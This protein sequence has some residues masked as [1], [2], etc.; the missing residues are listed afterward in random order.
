MSNP[1]GTNQVLQGAQPA[2]SQRTQAAI[3]DA[4]QRTGVDFGYLLAQARIE[5]GLNPAA[6]ARTSSATGLFQFLDQTWL[7]T[8]DRHGERLGFGQLA[9]AIDT[10][11]GRA[12]ITDPAMREAIMGLRYDPGASALMA[13]A[14]AGDNTA[15]LEQVLGRTPD[16][17]ELY[18]A[19]FLGPDGAS[20]MLTTLQT[21]PD[22]PAASLLPSAAHAN[23]GIFYGEGGA[24]R[25]VAQ[26]M[27]VIRS[28]MANAMEQGFELPAGSL[29]TV[30]LPGQP[31]GQPQRT[32]STPALPQVASLPPPGSGSMADLIGQTFGNSGN[33][34]A[35]AHVRRA[36]A[37]LSALG[38]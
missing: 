38:M 30:P 21:A 36:Y 22:T 12:R 14:L 5:S 13:G 10:S 24:A 33:S 32:F 29:D 3:A 20:R 9:Q 18:L 7:A 16:A 11:G 15:A 34:P 37:R 19:H 4:A 27:G 25:S 35:Q 2:R 1:L 28:R 23:R 6:R 31:N 17:S 8:L 26:V